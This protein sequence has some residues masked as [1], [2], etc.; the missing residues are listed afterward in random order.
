MEQTRELIEIINS[1][2][3]LLL[4]DDYPGFRTINNRYEFIGEDH[5]EWEF[6][7][8][9]QR[10]SDKKYFSFT[11]FDGYQGINRCLDKRDFTTLKEVKESTKL[12]TVY[13]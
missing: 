10:I 11:W 12:I 5:D 8:I 7:A 3:S 1:D 9:V 4:Y 2:I 6:E 13:E